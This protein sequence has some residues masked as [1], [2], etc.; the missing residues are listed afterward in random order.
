MGI[1]GLIPTLTAI[2]K[3]QNILLANKETL[4]TAG[5]IV[6]VPPAR[7]VIIIPVDSETA[8]SFSVCKGGDRGHK[9]IILTASGGSFYGKK[10]KDLESVTVVQALSHP[11]WDMGKKGYNRQFNSYQ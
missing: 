3:Q 9:R 10:R 6:M 1:A 5:D 8:R 11:N 7:N 4:V 2:E